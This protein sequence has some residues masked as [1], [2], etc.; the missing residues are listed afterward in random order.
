MDRRKHEDRLVCHSVKTMCVEGFSM[1]VEAGCSKEAIAQSKL[2]DRSK[3]EDRLVIH[4]VETMCAE[5]FRGGSKQVTRRKP[6]PS[7]S[8]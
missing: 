5:G 4:S 8:L 7:Q 6:F 3:H 1:C 2:V